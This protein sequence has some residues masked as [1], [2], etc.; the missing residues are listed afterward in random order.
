MTPDF[1]KARRI[2]RYLGRTAG[3]NKFPAK[4]SGRKKV[5]YVGVKCSQ[6][7]SP[8]QG[9]SRQA[10]KIRI[11]FEF[12]SFLNTRLEK[13]CRN[14]SDF[15]ARTLIEEREEFAGRAMSLSHVESHESRKS[16]LKTD[17]S[18]HS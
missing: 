8:V 15:D 10:S 13:R 16:G 7:W 2:F 18:S 3:V 14:T 17:H 11:T 5:G 1:T 9:P 12:N 6:T 4:K